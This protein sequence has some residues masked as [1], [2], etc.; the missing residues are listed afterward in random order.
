MG[1]NTS[2][3]MKLDA[4]CYPK[5]AV[6]STCCQFLADNYVFLEKAGSADDIKVTLTPKEGAGR[7][8]RQIKE[9]FQN[10]LVSNALRY[11]VSQ[12]NKDLRDYIIKSA[13]VFSQGSAVKSG[14]ALA[15]LEKDSKKYLAAQGDDWKDD[16]LGIAIPWEEKKKRPAGKRKK[17]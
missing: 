1:K 6:I 11:N 4:A 2:I 15:D 5:E 13:L 10:A 9:V 14:S 3:E 7:S 16:P 17:C 12:K 8:A